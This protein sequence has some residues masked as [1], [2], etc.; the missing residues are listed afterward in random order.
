MFGL[1]LSKKSEPLFFKAVWTGDERKTRD[2]LSGDLALV[3]AR[4]NAAVRRDHPE[5]EEGAT[6]LHLASRR[7]H[8]AIVELLLSLRADANAVSSSQATPLHCAA[9][10]GHADIATILLDRKVAIDAKDAQGCTPLHRAAGSGDE[11]L[12]EL[13]IARGASIAAKDQEGETPLHMAVR[14][15]WTPVAKILLT[16]GADVHARDGK[17]R[18]PIHSAVLGCVSAPAGR[19]ASSNPLSTDAIAALLNLLLS[20]GAQINELDQAGETPFDLLVYLGGKVADANLIHF[21]TSR[22]GKCVQHTRPSSRRPPLRRRPPR[23]RAS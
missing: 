16:A 10:G 2:T 12:V 13:L 19:G 17:G 22:G 21:F 18:M 14:S 11:E 20:Y 6:P 1:S 23:R 3:S 7:G 5:L 4:V 15:G 9:M 8:A